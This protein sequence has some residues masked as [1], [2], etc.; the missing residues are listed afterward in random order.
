MLGRELLQNGVL[1]VAVAVEPQTDVQLD[2][3]VAELFDPLVADQRADRA[4]DRGAR[5]ALAALLGRQSVEAVGDLLLGVLGDAGPALLSAGDV[6]EHAQLRLGDGVG[7]GELGQ[8][9]GEP[10]GGQAVARVA[11]HVVDGGVVGL[12]LE[13][14][15]LQFAAGAGVGALGGFAQLLSEDLEK[16]VEA[17]VARRGVRDGS[18]PSACWWIGCHRTSFDTQAVQRLAQ[19]SSRA[20]LFHRWR[21]VRMPGSG[22]LRA[23]ATKVN[24]S[25]IHFRFLQRNSSR[26]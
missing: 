14:D 18:W 10:V 26:A 12:V 7:D 11:G 16:V 6:E 22:A 8:E 23:G 4:V 19:K 13:G 15:V 17:R 2:H 3:A 24:C 9:L 5:D 20:C 25:L 1:G 21:A